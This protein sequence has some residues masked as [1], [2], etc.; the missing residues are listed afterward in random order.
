MLRICLQDHLLTIVASRDDVSLNDIRD[1]LYNSILLFT[2]RRIFLVYT[3][4]KPKNKLKINEIRFPHQLP[5]SVLEYCWTVRWDAY[6]YIYIYIYIYI[7]VCLC[8][9]VCMY[10]C[11][12]QILNF[13][14]GSESRGVTFYV[15][16]YLMSH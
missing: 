15:E 14:P 3:I 13:H 1:T 10:V 5:Y 9:Y 12:R 7:Y 16:P 4:L 2:V 8:V 6:T 11:V